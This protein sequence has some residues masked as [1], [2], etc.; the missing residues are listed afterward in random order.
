MKLK[1]KIFLIIILVIVN[2]MSAQNFTNQNNN[3]FLDPLSVKSLFLEQV[4][5]KKEIIGC[6]TGFIFQ[7]NSK[8]YLITNWHVVTG[9][10]PSNNQ[11][12]DKLGR[13]PTSI[14]IWHNAEKLGAWESRIEPLFSGEKKNWIEHPKGR[15]VDVVALPLTQVDSVITLY[16]FDLKLADTDMIP[17]VG[18][19]ISIIGFPQCMSGPGKMAIWKTGHIATEPDFDYNG[20]PF[21]I[22]DA[23][24]RQ[25][26]SGSPVVLRLTGGYQTRTGGTVMATSGM[27]T[28][29]LGIYSGQWT[30]SELGK[31]WFPKVIYE[32]LNKK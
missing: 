31:V 10:D 13:T 14:Q 27:R 21:F 19:P 12:L 28:K 26:M 15:D 4:D 16:P 11:I 30:I 7:Y 18:M 5:E 23:T 25:G 20:E 6:A 8:N 1:A 24:T 32:L 17:M 22:I 29:F 3:S 9:R 2:Y